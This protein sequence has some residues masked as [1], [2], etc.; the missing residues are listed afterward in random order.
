M[1]ERFRVSRVRGQAQP[2]R[3]FCSNSGNSSESR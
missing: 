3:R 1:S 2:R